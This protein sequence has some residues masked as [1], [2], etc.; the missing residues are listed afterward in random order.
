M[1]T[2]GIRLAFRVGSGK[3]S[4]EAAGW[5]VKTPKERPRNVTASEP[6]T[7]QFDCRISNRQRSQLE[8]R[9]PPFV[10]RTKFH[11]CSK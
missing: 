4:Y 3:R 5:L 1:N 2:L 7:E 8:S 9:V 6:H 11:E 10:D